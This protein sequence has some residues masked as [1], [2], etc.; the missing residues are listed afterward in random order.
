VVVVVVPQ[1]TFVPL[2]M[3]SAQTSPVVH[4]SPSSQALASGS[5]AKQLSAPSLQLSL[6]LPSPSGPVQGLPS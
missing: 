2:Q 4:D 6:Q 5:D 1:S 3:P